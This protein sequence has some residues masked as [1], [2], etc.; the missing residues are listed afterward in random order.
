MEAV[1]EAIDNGA[2]IRDIQE[3]NFSTYVKYFNGIERVFM[4]RLGERDWKTKVVIYWGETNL[5]KTTRAW[6]E[7][8]K[9][10]PGSVHNGLCGKWWQGYTCQEAV[11][12]DDFYPERTDYKMDYWLRLFDSKPLNIEVKG[13][14]APFLAKKIWITT[15]QDPQ[16][17]FRGYDQ[18]QRAAFFRRIE[19]IEHITE[20]WKSPEELLQEIED[21]EF[22]LA[23]EGIED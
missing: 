5:R 22:R 11:I 19:V 6:Y 7:A 15:N 4:A 21:A 16:E 9:E 20:E 3:N 1:K 10:F 17:W 23:L 8:R 18:T 13:S 14:S 12:L 2:S